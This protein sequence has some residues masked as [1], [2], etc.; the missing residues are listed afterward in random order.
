MEGGKEHGADILTKPLGPLLFK[1]HR[2]VLRD[3]EAGDRLERIKEEEPRARC[4]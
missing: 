2:A 4:A 1:R 3:E